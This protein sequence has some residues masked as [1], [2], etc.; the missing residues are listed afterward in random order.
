MNPQ[1][2]FREHIHNLIVNIPTHGQLVRTEEPTVDRFVLRFLYCKKVM[3]WEIILN[4]K[5]P[6]YPPDFIVEE[7]QEGWISLEQ[8]KSL[9]LWNPANPN[10]LLDIVLELFE[11]V[12]NYW[13]KLV[14]EC[15]DDRMQFEYST[16]STLTG[17]DFMYEQKERGTE[18][19][20][21]IPVS[22]DMRTDEKPPFLFLKYYPG[23]SKLPDT[24]LHC[25]S[26][27]IWYHILLEFKMPVWDIESCALTFL[28]ALKENIKISYEAWRSRNAMIVALLKIFDTNA[29]EC[30]TFGFRSISFLFER[31]GFAFVTLFTFPPD[32]PSKQPMITFLTIIHHK[33]GKPYQQENTAYPY[34][35]RWT[36]DEF[37]QRLRSW[38][39][40]ASSEFRKTVQQD[41]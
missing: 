4:V 32:F 34:S 18:V 20:C 37:A 19:S 36:S 3:Q 29:L 17:V 38:I 31:D 22:L 9:K 11:Q 30:D 41:N 21:M 12:K 40:D 24:Y 15:R 14:R 6:N 7:G 27:S 28:P 10:A 1:F 35:P 26:K 2:S 5:Q 25:S 39:L 16:I 13:K 23:T 33:N 8:C